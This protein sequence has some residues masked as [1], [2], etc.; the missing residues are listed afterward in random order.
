MVDLCVCVCVCECVYG[1][2]VVCV[3]S[4][5]YVCVCVSVC[6]VCVWCVWYVCVVCV[7]ICV[8][9]CVW[10]VCVWCVC[11]CVCVWCLCWSSP[12]ALSIGRSEILY[13]PLVL[14]QLSE[15]NGQPSCWV[16]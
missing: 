2:C 15:E 16:P 6:V 9:V 4:V 14:A 7:C 12:H 13:C 1:V 10:Y 8:C 5:W 11:V 3:L